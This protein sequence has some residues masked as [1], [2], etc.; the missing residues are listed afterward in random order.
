M[1]H[2]LV[3]LSRYLGSHIYFVSVVE[4]LIRLQTV[5]ID[6]AS[7]LDFELD[8]PIKSKVEVKAVLV[9]G[10]CTNRRNDQFSITGDVNS[11][12]PEICVLV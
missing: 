4:R 6:D 7:G 11:H 3:V 1:T 9:I 8:G 5:R 12:I 10:Y 2:V